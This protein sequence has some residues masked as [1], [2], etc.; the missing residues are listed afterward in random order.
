MEPS[1]IAGLIDILGHWGWQ[2]WFAA[3]VLA[4]IACVFITAKWMAKRHDK[5]LRELEKLRAEKDALLN[6]MLDSAENAKNLLV[7]A[8]E[9][10]TVA[11]KENSTMLER[12]QFK[13]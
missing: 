7:L 12:I 8:V 11:L 5:M 4:N 13:L 9:K 6:R 1:K 10:N 3:S 2:Q